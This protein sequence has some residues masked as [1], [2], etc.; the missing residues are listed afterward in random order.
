MLELGNLFL[1]LGNLLLELLVVLL[2]MFVLAG[3]MGERTFEETHALL[4]LIDL[5]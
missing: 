2:N 4:H 3:E 5:I 1:L